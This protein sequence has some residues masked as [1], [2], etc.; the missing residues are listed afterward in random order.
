MGPLHKG[1]QNLRLQLMSRIKDIKRDAK[2][3]DLRFGPLL[4]DHFVVTAVWKDGKGTDRNLPIMYGKH[5]FISITPRCA[6]LKDTY[7][8]Y[9]DDLVHKVLVARKVAK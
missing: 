8:G 5:S 1:L 2:L 6:Q 4:P 3:I 9:A 7:C